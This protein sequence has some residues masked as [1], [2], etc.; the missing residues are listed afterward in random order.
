MPITSQ[1]TLYGNVSRKPIL[2][3][4]TGSVG[5]ERIRASIGIT[6][7]V[8]SATIVM[9]RTYNVGGLFTFDISRAISDY[10]SQTH[11]TFNP[12]SGT[13]Y[14]NADRWCLVAVTFTEYDVVAGTFGDVIEEGTN[15]VS[16]SI[17]VLNSN[18]P[19]TQLLLTTDQQTGL[20]FLTNKTKGVAK[21]GYTEYLTLYKAGGGSATF[22]YYNASGLISS[23]TTPFGALLVMSLNIGLAIPAGTTWFE[24]LPG[25]TAANKIVYKVKDC[26][27]FSLHFVNMYG[28]VDTML[29]TQRLKIQSAKSSSYQ[30]VLPNAP[31]A[32]DTSLLR[33]GVDGALQYKYIANGLQKDEVDWLNEIIKTGYAVTEIGGAYVP[34]IVADGSGAEYDSKKKLFTYSVTVQISNEQE[35]VL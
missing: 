13:A 5:T 33:Y 10:F 28:Q 34:V 22:N 6:G 35:G 3:T 26:E 4:V 21:L 15:Y 31:T 11:L 8:G 2:F 19:H 14:S 18:L 20:K 27:V 1:P 25:N 17:I 32:L 24:V 29:F 9:D 7:G 30:K 23:A 16:T 12:I